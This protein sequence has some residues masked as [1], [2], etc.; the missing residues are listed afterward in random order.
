MQRSLYAGRVSIVIPVITALSILTT[1][2]LSIA[3]FGEVVSNVKW[4]GAAAI[5][6]GAADLAISR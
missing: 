6:V 3:M 5:I 2:L 4:L 1:F